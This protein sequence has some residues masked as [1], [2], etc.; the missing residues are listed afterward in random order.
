MM[1]I[2]RCLPLMPMYKSINAV[3]ST[4]IQA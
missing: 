4:V 1:F 2:D 3:I